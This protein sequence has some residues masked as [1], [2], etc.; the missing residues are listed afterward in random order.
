MADRQLT[1]QQL[2]LLT[3]WLDGE[4]SESEAAS[5]EALLA[6]PL[7]R[8]YVDEMRRLR[9]LVATGA[10]AA[11]PEGLA[12][13]VLERI[14]EPEPVGKVHRLPRGSWRTPFYAVAAALLLAFGVMFGPSLFGPGAETATG[15]IARE[16]L[17]PF[18]ETREQPESQADWGATEESV[19]DEVADE[20]AETLRAREAHDDARREIRLDATGAESA[21][22]SDEPADKPDSGSPQE[23]DAAPGLAGRVGAGG[24]PEPMRRARG[25]APAPSA[26]TTAEGGTAARRAGAPQSE[27]ES[28]PAPE[29][30]GPAEDGA[31]A[32]AHTVTVTTSRAAAAQ[33]ELLWVANLYGRATLV[34]AEGEN[35]GR[36]EVE[37][38]EANL[39]PL[40]TALSRSVETQKLGQISLSGALPPLQA[41]ADTDISGLPRPNAPTPN[42]PQ[43]KV[44][45]HFQS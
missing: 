29:Q 7:A 19:K 13:R 41:A 8:A 25:G 38:S 16:S 32:A 39:Q 42:Q 1:E 21:R 10:A 27:A 36:I 18:Y 40:A 23:N 15:D 22:D 24:S 20:L 12:E 6:D 33:A 11:A 3:A 28:E 43:T 4:A 45:I 2:E 37:L 26:D 44:T 34:M 30:A 17:A 31:E 35:A 9:E 5:V 14:R